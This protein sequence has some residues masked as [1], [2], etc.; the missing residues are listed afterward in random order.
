V[1]GRA[2]SKPLRADDFLSYDVL[3]AATKPQ[4]ARS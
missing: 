1:L 2:T 3:G 4:L